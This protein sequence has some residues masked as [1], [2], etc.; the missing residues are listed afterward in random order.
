MECEL[1]GELLCCIIVLIAANV[2]IIYLYVFISYRSLAGNPHF[3]APE[4]QECGV[5]HRN[6]Q[7]HRFVCTSF[8]KLKLEKVIFTVLLFILFGF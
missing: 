4:T 6:L 1:L 3:A 7:N 5:P 8:F 2:D